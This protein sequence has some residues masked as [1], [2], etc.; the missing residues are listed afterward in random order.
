MTMEN[1]TSTAA[2]MPTLDVSG[3]AEINGKTMTAMTRMGT[4]AL[5]HSID[6]QTQFL[7]FVRKRLDEDMRVAEALSCCQSPQDALDVVGNFYKTAF[8]NY[9]NEAQTLGD[10]VAQSAADTM[11]VVQEEM[12]EV[13]EKAS[14]A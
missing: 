4:D 9:T 8:E 11:K 5:R 13:S 6:M 2:T 10:E 14:A 7:G 12:K 3:L 1:N